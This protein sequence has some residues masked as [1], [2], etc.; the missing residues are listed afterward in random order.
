MSVINGQVDCLP[1]V[2]R[3]VLLSIPRLRLLLALGQGA[4][5]EIHSSKLVLMVSKVCPYSTSQ[6][7]FVLIHVH[8]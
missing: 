1:Q 3:Q 7:S 4:S 6:G 5:T 2:A 8:R